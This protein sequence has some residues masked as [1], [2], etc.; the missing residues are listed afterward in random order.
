M[1]DLI[2]YN[3]H[4]DSE[5][6]SL[7]WL[8]VMP[9]SRSGEVGLLAPLFAQV[10]LSL[11]AKD[12]SLNFIIPCAN[13]AR[14]AQIEAALAQVPMLNSERIVLIDA[15]SHEVMAGADQLCGG[16]LLAVNRDGVGCRKGARGNDDVV[17][18]T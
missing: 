2:N 1:I 6:Q 13:P 14:R 5:A 3:R 17:I 18:R 8:A 9:G 16:E 10:M 15:H 12:D 4:K 11:Q 7:K